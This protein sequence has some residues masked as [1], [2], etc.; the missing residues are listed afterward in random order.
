MTDF[1]WER[2]VT[3]VANH[4]MGAQRPGLSR[5]A[6]ARRS[7][8][9]PR[10]LRRSERSEPGAGERSERRRGLGPKLAGV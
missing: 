10:R 2:Y 7:A 9:R 4:W 6:R 3:R 1:S 8:P 5:A